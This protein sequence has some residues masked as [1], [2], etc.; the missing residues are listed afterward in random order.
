MHHQ[1]SPELALLVAHQQ[2]DEYRARAHAYR[3]RPPRRARPPSRLR[4]AAA[5]TLHRLADALAR[6]TS[7]APRRA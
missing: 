4:L 1:A 7:P 6:E 2:L 5:R 3:Q